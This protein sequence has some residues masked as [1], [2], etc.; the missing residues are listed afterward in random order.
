MNL[1]FFTWLIS[2][3][4]HGAVAGFFLIT[5]GGAALDQGTG[6]TT[7]VVEQGIAIEG[8]SRIGEA[9]TNIDAVEAPPPVVQSVPPMEEVKPLEE[10]VQHVIGS[11]F[12]PEQEQVTHEPKPEEVQEVEPE[13]IAAIEQTEIAVDEQRASGAKQTGGD[14][15]A[16]SAYRGKLFAHISSKK[17]NPRSRHS[18]T[19][20]IR[21]TVGEQG[22]LISRE[23]AASSGSKLLDDA[24]VASIERAAPFPAMPTEARR[25]GPMVVSV[26]FKFSVR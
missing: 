12:G 17:I 22:E 13:Q 16:M 18:G 5:P 15:T 9:Q 11:E 4:L 21:F 10:D 1:R 2:F 24:A 3:A 25:N 7:F 14:T 6:D 26:P 23:I 19:V 8:L 20:V